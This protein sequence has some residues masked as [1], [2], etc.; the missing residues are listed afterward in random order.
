[1]MSDYVNTPEGA[2]RFL[3][4]NP[5]S[6][7]SKNIPEDPTPTATKVREIEENQKRLHEL[8]GTMLATL[9]INMNRGDI[10]TSDDNMMRRLIAEWG[11]IRNECEV[12]K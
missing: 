12:S 6:F 10:I 4:E 5:I 3:Q 2:K 11:R 8:A 1:M 7:T 9:E